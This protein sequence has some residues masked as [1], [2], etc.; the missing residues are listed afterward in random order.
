M[1]SKL[2]N[3]LI[4]F[5]RLQ[6]KTNKSPANLGWLIT[7]K[8]DIADLCYFLNNEYK[9]ISRLL[10]TKH[11]K[12][13]IAP[14]IFSSK[15]DEYNIKW[16]AL[17]AE[18][19]KVGEERFLEEFANYLQMVTEQAIAEGKARTAEEFL[20]TEMERW[21]QEKPPE[22]L[23]PLVDNPAKIMNDLCDYL[24]GLVDNDYFDGLINNKHLEAWEF[25]TGTIGIDYSKIY[26]RWQS[27]PELFIPTHMLSRNITP[28][29]ELYNEA[30]R[31]YVFGLTEASVAMCRALLEHI[32]RKYYRFSGDDLSRVISEAKGN[33]GI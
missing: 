31:A 20:S 16:A 14:T 22:P 21:L 26:G 18:A 4:L 24:Q 9:E 7:E 32:L 10:I 28:I 11:N 5:V 1:K 17:V 15:W 27:S 2:E 30:V 8:P 12:H 25:F 19:A 29:E 13:T 33:M 6:N 23:D 3:F